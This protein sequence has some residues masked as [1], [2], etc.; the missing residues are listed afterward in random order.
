[1]ACIRFGKT[2]PELRRFDFCGIMPVTSFQRDFPMDDCVLCPGL[3]ASRSHIVL[4]DLP[5]FGRACPLL[6]IGEA[7]GG[8]EDAQ[9]K[10]FVGRSGRTL[11]RVLQEHGLFRGYHYGCANIVRCRPPQ[12]R[13]PTAEEIW[14]C[15]PLLVETIH[16]AKPRIFL[17]VGTTAAQAFFG[18]SPLLERIHQL[19]MNAYRVDTSLVHPQLQGLFQRGYHP[20]AFVIPHTSPLAWNRKAPNGRRWSDVGKQEIRTLARRLHTLPEQGHARGKSSLFAPE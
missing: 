10:G 15:L 5:E 18:A 6:I 8:D 2:H 12:N 9:G 3:C 17:L 16:F 20:A 14:N 1:M 7:P 4:P 11:H 13:K 19:R